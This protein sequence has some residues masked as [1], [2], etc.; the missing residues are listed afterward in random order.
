M[1]QEQY[2]S[3]S[4]IRISLLSFTLPLFF[5]HSHPCI[6]LILMKQ[7]VHVSIPWLYLSSHGHNHYVTSPLTV[8]FTLHQ[9]INTL[10]K[11][12]LYKWVPP[13]HPYPFSFFKRRVFFK[14]RFL[15]LP[16]PRC[17]FR[18]SICSHT[19]W[20]L[21]NAVQAIMQYLGRE[22]ITARMNVMLK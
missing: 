13:F 4:N 11:F 2:Y 20:C 10:N 15:S 19:T 21:A 14:K 9:L 12:T 22:A 7:S 1:W 16:D 6:I 17:F 8:N 18:Q 3:V 5:P